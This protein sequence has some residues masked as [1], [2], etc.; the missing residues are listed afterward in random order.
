VSVH[1]N[2]DVG[3]DLADPEVAAQ[4][5]EARDRLVRELRLPG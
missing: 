5:A 4:V 3:V 2:A 1:V